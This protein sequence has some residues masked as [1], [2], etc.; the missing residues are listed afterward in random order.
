MLDNKD[1]VEFLMKERN[2]AR[3]EVYI[4]IKTNLTML[5][6][7]FTI[8][9]VFLSFYL[10]KIDIS[11]SNRNYILLIVEQI[12]YI[13]LVF[14]LNLQCSIAS[15]AGYINSLEERINYFS[16]E[17]ICQWES[18]IVKKYY[19]NLRNNSGV[20]FSTFF[21]S[22]ILFIS[23]LLYAFIIQSIFGGFIFIIIHIVEIVFL[24]ILTRLALLDRKKSYDIT[25]LNYDTQ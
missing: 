9:G 12:G 1:K 6:S 20:V 10:G 23:F 8:F 19:M 2:L 22:F 14:N 4:Y 11:L 21:I 3:Q 18:V 17:T 13:I 15:L 16:N 24:I 5:F 7:F 25:K